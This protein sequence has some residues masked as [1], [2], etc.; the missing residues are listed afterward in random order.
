MLTIYK[1]S[2]INHS[3]IVCPCYFTVIDMLC[4]L[5][6]HSSGIKMLT[7]DLLLRGKITSEVL[8]AVIREGVAPG[9]TALG[10]LCSSA[11][12]VALL[13]SDKILRGKITPGADAVI[14]TCW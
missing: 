3:L 5:V 7:Q 9:M 10:S 14:V 2:I 6:S 8:N 1:Q 12:G 13:R 4:G 11:D